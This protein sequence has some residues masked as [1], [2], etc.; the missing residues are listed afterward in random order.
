MAYFDNSATTAVC[1][2]A[3]ERMMRLMT[4]VYGNPSSLH[5]MGVRAE[6]ELQRARREVAALIG[7]KPEQLVF[8]SGGTEANNLALLGSA[9]ACRRRPPVAV[10]TAVEHPSVAACFDEL[11]N[12]GWA[13]TRLKPQSDGTVSVQQLVEACTADT[14]LVSVMAVNNETGARFDIPAMVEA[15]RERAPQAL[16]H[17]D[18]VQAAG[19]LPIKAER[20]GVDL[21]SLSGHKLHAPKG[22]GALYIRRGV[23]LL[24]RALGGGQERGLRSGTEA[25]PAIAGFGAAAVATV[26]FEQQRERY[27]QLR[28]LL[29]EEL[30]TLPGIRWH[31]PPNGVPY[32]VH[33]SVVGIRS[34]TLLHFLAQRNIYVS[35]GSA[36]AK[37][38]HSPVL[39]AMGLPAEEI[40]SSLRISFCYEN[41]ANEVREL[42]AALREAAGTLQRRRPQ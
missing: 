1:S 19:K 26:P 20:W 42:A 36:C 41:T 35:S 39:E 8:T 4:E 16:F 14:T 32:I 10:T 33:F 29:R 17:T 9:A 27:E 6:E 7:A 5:T 2:A 28:A 31:L 22:C 15:V 37:G 30:S 24:P 18:C 40:D 25:M 11:E 23:R 13:V 21:L 3:V 38:Q 12:S 34:E